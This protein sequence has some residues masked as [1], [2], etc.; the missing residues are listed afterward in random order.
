MT[1]NAFVKSAGCP[2]DAAAQ[3]GKYVDLVEAERAF[4]DGAHR[5]GF[6]NPT[7][8]LGKASLLALCWSGG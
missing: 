1:D 5:V 4:V 3:L 7:R 6:A 8:A 2:G